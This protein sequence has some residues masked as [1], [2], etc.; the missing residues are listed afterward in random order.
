MRQ[1][2]L[3]TETTGLYPKQGHRIIEIGCVESHNRRSTGNTFHYYLDPEREIDDGAYEVHGIS[4]ESLKDKPNFVDIVEEFI[5]FIKGSELIIH[6]APFDVD[7]IN[8]ELQRSGPKWE[9][10]E[11]Y[12]EVTDTLKL[13]REMHP[14]QK[15]S[16]D[17][18]CKRYGI[19]NA[20][21]HD[22][23]GALL[24]ARILL[25]VY[26]AMTGGQAEILLQGDATRGNVD[27]SEESISDLP[28]SRLQVVEASTK[29]MAE[30]HSKLDEIDQESNGNCLWKKL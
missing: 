7:F 19:D 29:E 17:A 14:G 9:K 2:V 1:I 6:N 26:L 24:D 23:H 22:N 21:R 20:E 8:S 15:N 27:I 16:L 4:N 28:L 3:D 12:C 13:A 5:G 10:L 18:L 11:S 30:H 25:E